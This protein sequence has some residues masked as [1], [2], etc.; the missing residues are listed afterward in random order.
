MTLLVV[1]RGVH[2]GVC[3]HYLQTLTTQLQAFLDIDV[4]VIA[5]S[6][7]TQNKAKRAQQEWQLGNMMVGY[8]LSIRDGQRLGLF[9]SNAR[10]DSE[11]QTF[12]EPGLYLTTKTGELLF[13]SIQNM[14]FGRTQTAD[15]LHWVPKLIELE[16]P[17]RGTASYSELLPQKNTTALEI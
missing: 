11:P 16:I 5:V 17:P 15:L 13:V 7:D 9:V 1:Y 3:K 10:K 4:D 2:C 6:S 8:G 14:P 12:F